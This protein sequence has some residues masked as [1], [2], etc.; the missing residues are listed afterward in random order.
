MSQLSACT[1]ALM[2]LCRLM[3]ALLGGSLFAMHL[4]ASMQWCGIAIEMTGA[5]LPHD[6]V[7]QWRAL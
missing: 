7:P 1:C 3:A 6:A 5:L 2:L 4:S